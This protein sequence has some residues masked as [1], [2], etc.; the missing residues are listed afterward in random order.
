MPKSKNARTQKRCSPH[1]ASKDRLAELSLISEREACHCCELFKA[2]ADP[3]RLR[4]LGVLLSGEY[5]VCELSDVLGMSIS[6]VS[7]QL[8]L[9]RS[10][11]L[12]RGRREGRRTYYG[13][14]DDHVRS[15]L[16]EGLDHVRHD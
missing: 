6:A 9:L 15:L 1:P 5:C 7:H 16:A 8:R 12:V 3:N 14:D 11:R 10:Q 13:L 4:L 2:L